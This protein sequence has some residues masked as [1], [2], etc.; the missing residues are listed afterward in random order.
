MLLKKRKRMIVQTLESLNLQEIY[1]LLVKLLEKSPTSKSDLL[2]FFRTQDECKIINSHNTLSIIVMLTRQSVN[3]Y[4]IK[5]ECGQDSATFHELQWYAQYS[6]SGI[7]SAFIDGS[8]HGNISY[9]IMNYIHDLTSVADI[10]FENNSQVKPIYQWI[11][12]TFKADTSLFHLTER[13]TPPRIQYIDACEKLKLR[14]KEASQYPFLRAVVDN[15][16]FNINGK[17]CLSPQQLLSG[18]YSNTSQI[19]KIFGN[20]TGII[21]GDLH[22][23]NILLSPSFEDK[24]FIL[25][26]G[27]TKPLPIQYDG[28]KI[29][30]SVH[31]GY[32][33]IMRGQYSLF[34]HGKNTY[35][36]KIDEV[37]QFKDVYF[38]IC[39]TWDKKLLI[40]SLFMEAMHFLTVAP[41]HAQ[42]HDE[43]RVL[44][45]IGVQRLNEL[46]DILSSN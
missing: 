42:R 18:F 7:N 6:L 5:I 37:E 20:T 33:Q 1:S 29:L 32:E 13:T 19:E 8:T 36:L 14:I 9:I 46:V 43:A 40:G 16:T 21:H 25:D 27:S 30:Q 41:H 39:Q 10:V 26:P 12:T 2:D 24:L 4:A 28:G 38:H 17:S 45:L 35:S 3:R 11:D 22:I 15:K 23:G 44:Y 34:R 31:S